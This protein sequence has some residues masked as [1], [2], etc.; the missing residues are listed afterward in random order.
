[1]K[2]IKK[3]LLRKLIPFFIPSKKV[4][5]KE[6][7]DKEVEEVVLTLLR[8]FLQGVAELILR[9]G[10][11]LFMLLS[12]GWGK[13]FSFSEKSEYFPDPLGIG[14]IASLSLAT[15]AEFFC[16]ILLIFGL[17]TRFAAFNLLI[18][19]LVAGLIFHAADPFAK[20]ELALLYALVF[21]YFSI[22][23]GNRY[24][25]DQWFRK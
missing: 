15:F 14:S 23:G 13:L 19:M 18:T 11:G 5:G 6:L 3:N 16:S 24:S 12:H 10:V 1:M 9:V 25:L 22:V 7:D 17:F 4:E 2:K 8:Q 20:K 21:L